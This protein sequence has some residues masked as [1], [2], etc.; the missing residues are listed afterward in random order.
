[1][2]EFKEIVALLEK[3]HALVELLHLAVVE[4]A[5]SVASLKDFPSLV[6]CST[7]PLEVLDTVDELMEA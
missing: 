4:H 5:Q 7:K 1:M 3:L 2:E 6:F